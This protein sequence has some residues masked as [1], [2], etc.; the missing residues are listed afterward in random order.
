MN[1]KVFSQ[2][3][4]WSISLMIKKINKIKRVEI[5]DSMLA[6]R[7]LFS[8]NILIITDLKFI[9]EQLKH[10]SSWLTV[11]NQTV[12]MNHRRF[13]VMMHEICVTVLNCSQQVKVIKQLMRQ[14]CHLKK[15]LK[16]LYMCWFVKIIKHNK[17]IFYLMMNVI[18]SV[19]VNMLIDEDLLFQSELK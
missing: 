15:K 7:R 16:I 9:K 4:V 18:M 3:C 13:S 12:K 1:L 5:Q 17:A 6:A 11:I 8:E 19:Q 14:N 10:N 2:N